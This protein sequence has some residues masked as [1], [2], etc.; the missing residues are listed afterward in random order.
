MSEDQPHIDQPD[1]VMSE[2]AR[3]ARARLGEHAGFDPEAVAS[4]QAKIAK[5]ERMDEME[6]WAEVTGRVAEE[7]ARQQSEVD[8]Q[9]RGK[10]DD[11]RRTGD[12][13]ISKIQEEHSRKSRIISQK[14]VTVQTSQSEVARLE[15]EVLP[16]F[17]EE[18]IQQKA[19]KK[20]VHKSYGQVNTGPNGDITTV[21]SMRKETQAFERPST[22]VP[23]QP[24][25]ANE[26]TY[27][28]EDGD[29]VIVSK[30][31]SPKNIPQPPENQER[32]AA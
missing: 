18:K 20:Q 26:T 12:I 28:H 4:E 9:L 13:D 29:A 5:Q 1:E 23:F 7:K 27:V 6:Q 19:L 21:E 31:R 32:P 25:S 17:D 8:R 16:V 2:A 15:D 14:P 3:A 10:V 30:L 22:D 11:G 24:S